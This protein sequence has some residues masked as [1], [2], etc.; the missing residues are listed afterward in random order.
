M[1]DT[2]VG[3]TDLWLTTTDT[4]YPKREHIV[5]GA[6]EETLSPATWRRR[7]LT[8]SPRRTCRRHLAAAI[9]FKRTSSHRTFDTP[10]KRSPDAE[11]PAI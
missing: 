3:A 8:A 6:G 11:R 5:G 1:A 4:I 7:P 2:F 10:A 9:P